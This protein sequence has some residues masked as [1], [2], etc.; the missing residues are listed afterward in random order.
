MIWHYKCVLNA[1]STSNFFAHILKDLLVQMAKLLFRLYGHIPVARYT[2]FILL[3]VNYASH[4][5]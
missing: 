4:A 2:A 1:H 5:F 3:S